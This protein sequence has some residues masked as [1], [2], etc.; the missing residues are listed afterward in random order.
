MAVEIRQMTVEEYLALDEASEIQHEFINGELIPMPGGSGPHNSIVARTIGALLDAVGDRDCTV[1]GS[2]M[3]VEIDESKYLFPDVSVVCGE[4]AYGD[5]NKV[6]LLNPT[7]VVEV[8]SPS[9]IERD[10]IHKV[11]LY[12][13]VPSIRGY[14]ILDQKRVFAQWNLR[15]DSGWHTRQFTD[16]TDEIELEPLGCA[17]SLGPLYRG[18]NLESL[19]SAR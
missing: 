3:R 4:P 2:Q 1:F 10:H 9:S 18:V 5:Y 17:L 13:A 11:E 14:L 6:I 12:S 19:P 7:V 15:T 8:T 16:P